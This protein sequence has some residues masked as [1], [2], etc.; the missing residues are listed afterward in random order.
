MHVTRRYRHR[1][2]RAGLWAW[3]LGFLLGPLVHLAG[4]RLDHHHG[5]GG[6]FTAAEHRHDAGAPADSTPPEA[7]GAGA[8]ARRRRA[9][10]VPPP[11][12]SGRLPR[13]RLRLFSA[14]T[15]AL[16]ARQRSAQPRAPP[17]LA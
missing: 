7:D 11:V 2:A 15:P 3:C 5:G 10:A 9:R 1:A 17:P 12:F 16:P 4:H 14:H 8:P 6:L 13:H